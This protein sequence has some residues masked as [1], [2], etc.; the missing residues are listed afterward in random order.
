MQLSVF[1]VLGQITVI[2]SVTKLHGKK[3]AGSKAQ[4]HVLTYWIKSLNLHVNSK[5]KKDQAAPAQRSFMS[6]HTTVS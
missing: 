6:L 2:E 1:N 4:L 5:T 3:K